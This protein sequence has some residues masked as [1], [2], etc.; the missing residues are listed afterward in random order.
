VRWFDPVAQ[1][2]RRRPLVELNVGDGTVLETVFFNSCG[3]IFTDASGTRR[4]TGWPASAPIGGNQA[5]S[6]SVVDRLMSSPD[7]TSDDADAWISQVQVD[8]SIG[9]STSGVWLYCTA[10]LQVPEPS[11]LWL[12]AFALAGLGYG[13][14]RRRRAGA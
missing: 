9:Q 10:P 7:L 4:I 3:T 14:W 12:L 1:S 8:K 2:V 5:Y 6:P 13:R 11:I